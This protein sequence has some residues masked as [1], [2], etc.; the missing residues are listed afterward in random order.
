[1]KNETKTSSKAIGVMV[2]GVLE[3]THP[4]A[5]G[6]TG[7]PCAGLGGNDPATGQTGVVVAP[8]GTK[9]SCVQCKTIWAQVMALRLRPADFA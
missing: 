5:A 3:C 2:D 1:M 6:P 8:R 9:I 4:T 7:F